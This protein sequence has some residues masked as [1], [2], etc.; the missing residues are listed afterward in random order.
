MRK[1]SSTVLRDYMSFVRFEDG[2]SRR[3]R[4]TRTSAYQTHE[5]E[6]GVGNFNNWRTILD[7]HSDVKSSG[8]LLLTGNG[9]HIIE[10][11]NLGIGT[12]SPKAKLAVEGNILA[13]EIK[14]TNNIAVPD[15]VFE[16]D[17]KLTSLSEIETY[18]KEHKH[19]PEIPSAKDIEESGLDLGEMNLLLLKKVEELTLHLIENE[20]K[21]DVLEKRLNE[22]EG[23]LVDTRRGI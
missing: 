17:Y 14:V 1:L 2:D 11:G 9:N 12:I 15:Y 23:E 4:H 20:K 8:K 7:S 19:L 22:V 16:V 10:N 3:R 13:K 6:N 21:M 5:S 18:V